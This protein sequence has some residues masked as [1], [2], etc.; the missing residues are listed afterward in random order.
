MVTVVNGLLGRDVDELLDLLTRSTRSVPEWERAK[1]I[2][3][4]ARLMFLPDEGGPPL[5]ALS[6]GRPDVPLPAPDADFPF[7]P[8]VLVG[9]L[10]FL[11]VGGYRVGGA[12]N[13]EGWFRQVATA[14]VLR[15]DPL[16]PDRSPVDAVDALITDARWQRLTSDPYRSRLEN[17]VR[18]QSLR[19]ARP[20]YSVPEHTLDQL[21]ATSTAGA[22]EDLWEPMLS[23]VRAL[24]LCWDP[25]L[26]C[27][28]PS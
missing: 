13:L 17:M 11:C 7:L 1:R 21:L 5:P 18:A 19:A 26:S 2:A 8:L 10:P 20:A 9:D 28:R 25:G 27:F 24:S 12:F 6:L 4:V 14:G 22:A 15:C 3:L 16:V 23:A